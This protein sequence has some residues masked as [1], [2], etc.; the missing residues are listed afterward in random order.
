MNSESNLSGI[1]SPMRKDVLRNTIEKTSEALSVLSYVIVNQPNRREAKRL[2]GSYKRGALTLQELDES[3]ERS[4]NFG[5]DP[6]RIRMSILMTGDG[7][8][9]HSADGRETL[10][11]D[12]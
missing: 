10:L 2:Y 4:K 6:S 12:R 1:I 5:F 3:I 11:D 9:I 8:S 7:F